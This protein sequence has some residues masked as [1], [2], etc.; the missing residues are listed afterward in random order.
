MYNNGFGVRVFAFNANDF[1]AHTKPTQALST[2]A[3]HLL[4]PCYKSG[5]MLDKITKACYSNI[6]HVF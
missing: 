6:L 3:T 2:L 5:A 4:Q 1:F